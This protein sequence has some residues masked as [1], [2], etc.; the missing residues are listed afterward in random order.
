[1]KMRILEHLI[2]PKNC[3]LLANPDGVGIESENPW[4]ITIIIAIEVDNGN[5]K[6]IGFKTK[7]CA[8]SIASASALTELV[9]GKSIEEAI[10]ISV[11][12]VSGALGKIPTEKLHC[13]RLA[14][15]ALHRAIDDYARKNSSQFSALTTKSTL[16]GEAFQ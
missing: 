14:R 10:S 6:K 5:I 4:M 15:Q 2:S 3:G 1:M 16:P 9:Q 8:T 7:G 11:E 13:C 12:E